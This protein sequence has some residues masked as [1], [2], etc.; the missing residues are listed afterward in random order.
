MELEERLVKLEAENAVQ[1]AVIRALVEMLPP[2]NSV[3][4]APLL[5][6][7]QSINH[8]AA[9]EPD[10]MKQALQDALSGLNPMQIPRRR[11]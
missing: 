5:R 4:D 2:M 6:A 9:E 1:S 8:R 11:A 3:L 10:P 7:V